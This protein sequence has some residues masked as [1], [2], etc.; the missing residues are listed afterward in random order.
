MNFILHL[1][2][3]M[4]MISFEGIINDPHYVSKGEQRIL[5]AILGIHGLLVICIHL[6]TYEYSLMCAN[7]S[8]GADVDD[9]IST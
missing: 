7:N 8:V 2:E 5:P 6:T 3:C 4:K 1:Q 9:W